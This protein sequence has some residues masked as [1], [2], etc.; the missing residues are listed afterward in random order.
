[1]T[2]SPPNDASSLLILSQSD[3]HGLHC[4]PREILGVVANAFTGL[5]NQASANPVKTIV[6]PAD[7]R[8]IAYSMTGRDGHTKT[9]GFKL[10]YEF[11][12]ERQHDQYQNHSLMFLCDDATGKPL[13][14][15]DVIAIDA[16][17]TAATTALLAK[18]AAHEQTRSALL[19]GTGLI[20]QRVLPLLTAAVPQLERLMVYG[21]HEAGAQRVKQDLERQ[22]PERTVEIVR[23]LQDAAR[24]ADIVIGATGAGAVH[25]VH[26]AWLRPG[27]V[28]VLLGYGIHADALHNADYRIATDETQMHV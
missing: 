27:V 28:S 19:V 5:R 7:K 26:H 17:R 3:L 1:M 6:Q 20:G 14:V 4:T 15:M 21:T 18:A 25:A 23:D 16:L 9:V 12:P 11:D 24:A 13:A 8:S 10:A 22:S 2:L